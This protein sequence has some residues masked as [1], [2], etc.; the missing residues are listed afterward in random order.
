M[1]EAERL[2]VLRVCLVVAHLVLPRD[3]NVRHFRVLRT[4][5]TVVMQVSVLQRLDQ[6][7]R[8][9]QP[10]GRLHHWRLPTLL[11]SLHAI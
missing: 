3:F 7:R 10:L 4:V 1:Q 2:V 6:F 5:Q 9:G 11:S 8:A